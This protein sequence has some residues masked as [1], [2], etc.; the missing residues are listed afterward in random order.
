MHGHLVA[1]EVG[2]ECRT[3]QRVQLYSLTFD[4]LR[5]ESLNTETVQ[6]RGT[7][8]EYGVSFHHVLKDIP[9]DGIFPIDNFFRRLHRFHD[10]ALDEFADNER[11][12]KFGCHIFRQTALIH[13]QFRTYNNNRTR[14]IVYTFTEKI[15]TETTLFSF[16]TIGKRFQ[17]T[18]G[19]GLHGT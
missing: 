5:L 17:R 15:L 12:I 3:C 18:V 4:H 7:V 10:T 9:H 2:I 6:G 14:R 11:F 13:F 19:I 16:Q 1:V 8:E